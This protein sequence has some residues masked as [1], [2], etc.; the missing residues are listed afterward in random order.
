MQANVSYAVSDSSLLER[1][2]TPMASLDDA[3]TQAVPVVNAPTMPGRSLPRECLI[4][5]LGDEEY[6]FDI[7]RVQEI[8]SYE[9]PT[10]IA[11]A[12]SHVKGV[13]NLRGVIVPI[14]DLRLQFGLPDARYDSITVVVVLNVRGKVVGAVV[15]SV[16]DVLELSADSIK[17]APE[18]NG[19]VACE[20][21]LGVATT[22]QG[23]DERLLIVTDIETLMS[24]AELGLAA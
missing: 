2:G 13:I 23:D 24:G 12:P 5:R 22:R 3:V 15:D 10:R 21:I 14:V 1:T 9:S 4:F 20:H 16:S 18:F 7:L 8:R 11:G 19:S 17:P 6:G